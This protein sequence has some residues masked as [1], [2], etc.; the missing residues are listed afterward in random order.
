MTFTE[1]IHCTSGAHCQTCRD[2]IDGCMWRAR[3]AI[4]FGIGERDWTCPHGKAWGHMGPA[5]PRPQQSEIDLMLARVAAVTEPDAQSEGALY[6]RAVAAQMASLYY[7]RQGSCGCSATKHRE[8]VLA[9]IKQHITEYQRRKDIDSV[10]V[11]V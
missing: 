11:A 4:A 2:L 3:V 7:E 10:A 5:R 8:R 9:K 6:L 1:S